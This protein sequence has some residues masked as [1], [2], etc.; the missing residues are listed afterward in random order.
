MGSL[1][2]DQLI[3]LFFGLSFSPGINARNPNPANRTSST[4]YKIQTSVHSIIS[5]EWLYLESTGNKLNGGR[6]GDTM[7]WRRTS[8][9]H[10]RLVRVVVAGWRRLAKPKIPATFCVLPGSQ[11]GSALCR[12][13]AA[14]RSISRPITPHQLCYF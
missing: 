9:T 3:D 7:V 5:R 2:F 13:Q 4:Q 14:W 11:Q 12:L 8:D 10:P 6:L 1:I